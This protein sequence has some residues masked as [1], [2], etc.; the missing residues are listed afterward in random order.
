MKKPKE[1]PFDG[2]LTVSEA[3]AMTKDQAGQ[4]YLVI[5]NGSTWTFVTSEELERFANEG[6]TAETLNAVLPE[7]VVPHLYSDQELDVALRYTQEWKVIPVVSRTNH[8]RLR[9]VLELVD[10]LNAYRQAGTVE[11]EW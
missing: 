11:S 5:K 7:R 8:S 2:K 6:R 3:R 4:T 10:V 9:G 1:N